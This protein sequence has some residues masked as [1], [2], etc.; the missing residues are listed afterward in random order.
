[1]LSLGNKDVLRI[2]KERNVRFVRL[3]FTDILV[4]VTDYGLDKYFS[5]L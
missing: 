4:R 1:M 5:I 2:L 3:W